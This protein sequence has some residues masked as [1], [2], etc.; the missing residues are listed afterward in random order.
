M[1][2]DRHFDRAPRGIRQVSEL[3]A[4]AARAVLRESAR[5]IVCMSGMRDRIDREAEGEYDERCP[6]P[7]RW[8]ANCT[9]QSHAGRLSCGRRRVKGFAPSR[10]R[11]IPFTGVVAAAESF[12]HNRSN[13]S[14][15]VVFECRSKSLPASP[16]HSRSLPPPMGPIRL[17][18]DLR[19]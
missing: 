11:P 13:S 18:E 15:D 9:K 12:R 4:V 2:R 1:Q 8:I 6:Q 19:R 10:R 14:T 5:G 16:Q 7:G 3:D 17:S